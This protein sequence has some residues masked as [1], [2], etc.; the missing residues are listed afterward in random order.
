[1][2][3]YFCVVYSG[4]GEIY[5]TRSCISDN[6]DFEIYS[7]PAEDI[8]EVWKVRMKLTSYLDAPASKSDTD[9][10]TRQLTAQQKMLESLQHHLTRSI[11]E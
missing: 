9:I 5:N 4:A 2:A 11:A 6:D 3:L 8:L 10:I 1:V 7:L